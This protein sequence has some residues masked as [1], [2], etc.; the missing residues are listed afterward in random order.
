[1]G[2]KFVNK[3]I[4]KTNKESGRGTPDIEERYIY[5]CVYIYLICN[6]HYILYN[7]YIT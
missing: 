4:E 2:V 1:M 6:I 5:V 7:K 3:Q